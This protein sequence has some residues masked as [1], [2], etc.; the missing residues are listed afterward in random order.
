MERVSKFAVFGYV[1]L[2]I[3]IVLIL[4]IAQE[5]LL[6]LPRIIGQGIGM[7][8]GTLAFYPILKWW[9]SKRPAKKTHDSKIVGASDAVR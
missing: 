8:M 7:F 4:S 9:E 2:W 3:A 5:R 6:N 1:L